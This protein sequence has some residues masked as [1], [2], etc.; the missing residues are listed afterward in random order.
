MKVVVCIK[1]VPDTLDIGVDRETGLLIRDKAPAVINP[2]DTYAVEEGLLITEKM[3]GSVTA[4]TMGPA[5]AIDVLHEAMSMG[6][7]QAVHICDGPFRGSDTFATAKIL[8]AAIKKIGDADLILCGKQAIDGDTAQVG[9][10][11]AEFLDIPHVAYVKKIRQ[12]NEKSIVLERMVETGVEVIEI[13]LP[14]MLTVLKDINTPRMPSF[15]LKRQAKKQELPVWGAK[16]LGL[17]EEEVGLSGSPTT[18]MK[19]F[20][21]EARGGCEML[22][23]TCDQMVATLMGKLEAA[24][25]IGG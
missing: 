19:T 2:F 14:A 13:Q 23:G 9:P 3:G 22:E 5:S 16:E 6:V 7:G 21:A 17:S 25:V 24:Q 18:V 11:I 20:T 8:S 10:E 1:Q 15:R 12:V 4:L